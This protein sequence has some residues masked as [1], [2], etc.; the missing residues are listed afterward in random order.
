M[1][2]IYTINATCN[3]GGMERILSSKVNYLAD[4][5]NYEIIIVTTEQ[6]NR[7]HFFHFS[8]KIR[9]VDLGINY[10]EDKDCS[11][12][13]RLIRQTRK[14]RKHRRLLFTLLQQEKPDISISMFDRDYDFL[15]K[16]KDGSR[17]VLEYHFSKYVKRFEAGNVLMKMVQSLRIGWWNILIRRYDAFVVLTEEDK[18]QWGSLPNVY[19]IPNFIDRLPENISDLS[20]KT[21]M[22]AGRVSHQ[23]G[24]DLLIEAWRIVSLQN[25][26]WELKIVGGGDKSILED[27]RC[28]YNLHNIR[29]IPATLNI[30]K[31]YNSSSLFVLSSRYEGFGL[32]LIEAMSHGLPLVSFECPCGPRDIIDSSFG[33]LVSNGSITQLAAALMLFIEDP[34]KRKTAGIHARE[35]VKKYEQKKV[36]TLWVHLFNNLLK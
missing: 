21:V 7:Q 5:L 1:K 11:I 31:E 32:V 33:E 34:E 2:I 19:V 24:F 9:F 3:S 22:A 18:K 25:P 12:L 29:L 17:K 13:L 20:S 27:M 15:Y 10:D 30:D 14:K 4:H 16:L 8:D 28:K 6:R 23:K 35:A 36:M 26:D